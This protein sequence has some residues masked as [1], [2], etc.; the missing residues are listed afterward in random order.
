MGGR[1]VDAL[2]VPREVPLAV[3]VCLSSRCGFFYLI[4]CQMLLVLI[5]FSQGAKFQTG[6]SNPGNGGKKGEAKNAQAY[7]SVLFR[8]ITSNSVDM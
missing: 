2:L 4:L 3:F 5:Y 7:L 1:R 8:C 6:I